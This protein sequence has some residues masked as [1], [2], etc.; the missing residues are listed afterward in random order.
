MQLGRIVSYLMTYEMKFMR[1]FLVLYRDLLRKI[2]D[3]VF[4]GYYVFTSYRSLW[5]YEDSVIFV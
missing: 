3:E 4:T 5:M 1:H 2:H